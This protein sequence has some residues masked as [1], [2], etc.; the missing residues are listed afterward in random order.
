MEEILIKTYLGASVVMLATSFFILKKA[1]KRND[2]TIGLL[3]EAIERE[4]GYSKLTVFV[5]KRAI[6]LYEERGEFEISAKIKEA[7]YGKDDDEVIDTPKGLFV[8]VDPQTGISIHK[9]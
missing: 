1:R 9:I 8:H 6:S 3:N 2:E 7:I 5:W 4:Q